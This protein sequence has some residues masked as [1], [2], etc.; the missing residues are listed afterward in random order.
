MR[1]KYIK[2]LLRWLPVLVIFTGAYFVLTSASSTE[3]NSPFYNPEGFHTSE[4]LNLYRS[5]MTDLPEETNSVF[6]GSGVC[7]G[8]HGYDPN[9]IA[10]VD[11]NGEDVNVVDDWRASMMANSAKDP[12][13]RAKVSHEITVNP[14]H[15]TELED[16]CTSC[17]APMGHY[18]AHHDGLSNYTMSILSTDS[19]GLD[20]V[21]CNACHQQNPVGIGENFSGE[22]D[23]V[24]DTLFGPYGNDPEEPPLFSQPMQS[25]VGFL[26]EYGAHI[27]SSELCASCH[28]LQT[29][30]VDLEGNTTG[31]KFVEQATYHEWLNSVYST[32]V[33]PIECQ[34]CHFPQIPDT[35][36]ISANYA[37]LPGRA[38]Y[39]LHT[40]AG[41][42]SF[43]L[44]LMRDNIAELGISATEE[45]FDSMI[46]RTLDNLQN[47]SVEM[48]LSEVELGVDTTTYEVKLTNLTGHKFPSGYPARRA[49]VEFVV[50]G[51]DQDTLFQS[52]VLEQDY[53]V[54]GQNPTYEPHYNEISNEEQVQIYELVMGDVNGDVTTVLERGDHAIKDNRL[55]PIGFSTSH[56]SYDTT[57]IAGLAL[58]DSNFN[59]EDGEEG[60]GSDRILY[61]IPMNGYEGQINVSA[62]LFYQSAPPKWMEEMF[63]EN[64]LEILSFKEM[65]EET[66]ADPVLV[67]E[68]TMGAV[69]TYV[70]QQALKNLR[71]YPNPTGNGWFSIDTKGALSLNQVTAYDLNG[72]KVLD[73]SFDDTSKA[74]LQLPVEAGVYVV[75]VETNKGVKILR[76]MVGR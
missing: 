62:R 9:E 10:S 41:G 11:D 35:V 30:T 13:W 7:E 18:A 36:V 73:K 24:M 17:H 56:E 22:L 21:S 44:E 71:A 6:A 72:R 50:T 2:K 23:Y 55:T 46:S 32:E 45:Q 65:Y 27:G 48:E 15:Q 37:F 40:M 64:T 69:I 5:M 14:N 31:N 3:K 43:M 25:F 8:C 63:S 57:L 54:F 60:S 67:A 75:K 49:F 29:N 28:T 39:G 33:N 20:G 52:G 66:G 51:A 4:E 76:V 70:E 16:K 53:E 68:E 59:Y 26:P 19:L 34:G 74:K 58:D 47:Q 42:N 12:F 38:P 1:N 61:R